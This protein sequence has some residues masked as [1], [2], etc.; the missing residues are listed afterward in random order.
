MGNEVLVTSE[1][2]PIEIAL[3]I[4]DQGFT[5]AKSLY[6]WLELNSTHYAR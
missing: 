4:D 5:T 3:H 6:N 1:Q 2:T